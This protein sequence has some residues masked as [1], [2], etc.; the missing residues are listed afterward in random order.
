MGADWRSRI[1]TKKFLLSQELFIVSTC[2]LFANIGGCTFDAFALFGL[3]LLGGF[4]YADYHEK[5]MKNGNGG[6]DPAGK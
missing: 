2:A 3:A 6:A 4:S 5:K 1:F